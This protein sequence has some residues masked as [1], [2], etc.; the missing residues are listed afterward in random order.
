MKKGKAPIGPDGRSIDAHHMLQ[1]QHGPIAEMTKTF[2]QQYKK[3]IH[4]NSNKV[5]SGINRDKFD[6]WRKQY[7][8]NRAKEFE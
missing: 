4:I 5:P 8:K 1:T 2:H 6:S 7:W 3:V